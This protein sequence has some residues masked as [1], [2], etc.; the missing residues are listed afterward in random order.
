[1]G[2]LAIIIATVYAGCAIAVAKLVHEEAAE[3]GSNEYWLAMAVLIPLAP[4]IVLAG[5]I[6]RMARR[7]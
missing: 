4:A 1:M 3:V 5:A 6:C 7:P 2:M